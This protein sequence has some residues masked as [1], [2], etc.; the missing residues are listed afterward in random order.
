MTTSCSTTKSNNPIASESWCLNS[1]L[2]LPSVRRWSL[3]DQRIMY[4]QRWNDMSE[5]VW[6][7]FRIVYLRVSPCSSIILS[8]MKTRCWCCRSMDF[9][10]IISI[11]TWRRPWKN[12]VSRAIALLA[13]LRP[14]YCHKCDLLPVEKYEVETFMFLG[15]S[16]YIDSSFKLCRY[17]FKC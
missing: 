16:N 13:L 6:E 2:H 14:W 9:D 4:T 3:L 12:L 10:R 11:G 17:A 15:V 8:D 7:F 5:R 1:G